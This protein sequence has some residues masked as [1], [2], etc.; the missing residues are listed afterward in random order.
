ML[1]MLHARFQNGSDAG[2]LE[3]GAG[4]ALACAYASSDEY[5]AE[6]IHIRRM[7]GAYGARRQRLIYGLAWLAAL[8]VAVVLLG[9]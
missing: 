8:A 4:L 7:A 3:A 5:E 1:G 6:I 2:A 9:S